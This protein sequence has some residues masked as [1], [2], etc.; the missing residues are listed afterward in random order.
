MLKKLEYCQIFTG[1]GRC[2]AGFRRVTL[3]KSA[4]LFVMIVTA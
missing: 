1:S 4:E 3:D 2:Q